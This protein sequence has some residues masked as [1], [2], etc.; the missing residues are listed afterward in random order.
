MLP[1]K[2][3]LD[4]IF[5]SSSNYAQGN[6]LLKSKVVSVYFPFKYVA[7]KTSNEGKITFSVTSDAN[8]DNNTY[9]FELK[10]PII[11]NRNTALK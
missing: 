5:L 8:F 3:T 2:L 7:L 4:S 10:T 11:K 9:K 1:S 6:F